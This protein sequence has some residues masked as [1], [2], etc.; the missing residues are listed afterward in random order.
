MLGGRGRGVEKEP[1]PETG[2]HDDKNLKSSLINSKDPELC[3]LN[4]LS[5]EVHNPFSHGSPRRRDSRRFT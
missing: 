1:N 5:I 3:S 4:V 2:E